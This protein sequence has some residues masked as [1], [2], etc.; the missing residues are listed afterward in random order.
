MYVRFF[1]N[2]GD[3]PETI[4][5]N[6]TDQPLQE[7]EA[8]SPAK[9]I[10]KLTED[11]SPCSP[12]T[13]EIE[14]L[15]STTPG[16]GQS[17]CFTWSRSFAEKSS[18]P[19]LSQSIALLKQYQR[20]SKDTSKDNSVTGSQITSPANKESDEE[21]SPLKELQC[22]S[23]QN[24]DKLLQSKVDTSEKSP[25]TKKNATPTEVRLFDVLVKQFI[26]LSWH[27]RDCPNLFIFV[28]TATHLALP[29]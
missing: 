22:P 10:N 12:K 14:R 6:K 3:L 9:E 19:S 4:S 28:A 24:L 5:K 2:I 23:K 27:S 29:S 26:K 8:D 25:M 17:S 1:C 13:G 18:T 21:T 11:Q 7:N 20:P 16:V 15:S